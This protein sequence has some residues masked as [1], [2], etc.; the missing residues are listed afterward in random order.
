MSRLKRTLTSGG[1]HTPYVLRR[2]L[3]KKNS[4][5]RTSLRAFGEASGLFKD[6]AVHDFGKGQ[7]SP[8]GSGAPFEIGVVLDGKP[9]NLPYVGYGVSQ[10]LPIVV[11]VLLGSTADVYL[12]QQPEVHLHPR[13][14]AALGDLIHRIKSFDDRSFLIETHSD[15]LIDRYR[16]ARHADSHSVEN[17]PS[18]VLYFEQKAGFNSTFVVEIERDGSYDDDQPR[19]FRE[20]FMKEQI[21]LLKI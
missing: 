12:V 7:A 3:S 13:A 4:K 18:S 8:S 1:S 17:E 21:E 10:V 2:E 19:G 9:I 6:I 20:F 14:Q 11:D 5:L 15:F 16:L